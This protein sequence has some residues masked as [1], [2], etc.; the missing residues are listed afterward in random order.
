MEGLDWVHR[1]INIGPLKYF[2][3]NFSFVRKS[4]GA[5]S[6]RSDGQRVAC[7]ERVRNALIG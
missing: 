1:N 3:A 7:T 4:S 6:H 2:F 5:V